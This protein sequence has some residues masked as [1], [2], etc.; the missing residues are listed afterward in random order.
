MFERFTDQARRAV[1]L[2]QEEARLL[3]HDYIGSEH[4]LLGLIDEGDGVAAKALKRL[5][6]T[7]QAVHQQVEETVGRGERPAPAGHIPFAREAKKVLQLSLRAA[8]QLGDNYIDTGHILLG[9]TREKQSP[10][11]QVLMHLGAD[12]VR[13]HRQV[14]ELLHGGEGEGGPRTERGTGRPGG[15]SRGNRR[16]L[17]ELLAR[18]GSLES[19]LS[20]LEHRVGTGPDVRDLDREIAQVRRDKETA[21]DDQDFE[22][23]AALRDR[24][25]DLLSEKAT[26]R[27]A[28]A[29]AHPDLPPLTAEVERLRDLLREHGIDPDPQDGAA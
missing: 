28:W 10:G 25:K 18:F 4:I 11:A 20:A 7:E 26:R 23:A 19:R 3:N 2:A 17:S 8:L 13:V 27:E 15:T 12:L 24:E 1:V 14:I 6:I 22:T 16:L 9:L 5:G 21:I 29:A